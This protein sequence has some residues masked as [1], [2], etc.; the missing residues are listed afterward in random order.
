MRVFRLEIPANDRP[1]HAVNPNKMSGLAHYIQ[2]HRWQAVLR[3]AYITAA[4]PASVV[5]D[6]MSISSPD[7]V[8]YSTLGRIVRI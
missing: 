4:M 1:I 8:R 5:D 7:V 3:T 6:L 2:V